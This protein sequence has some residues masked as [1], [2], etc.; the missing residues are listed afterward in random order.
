MTRSDKKSNVT[1]LLIVNIDVYQKKQIKHTILY[2]QWLQVSAT[3]PENEYKI[4]LCI[5]N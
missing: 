2:F 5:V 1:E 3:D 4:F